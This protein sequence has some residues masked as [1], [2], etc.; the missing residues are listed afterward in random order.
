MLSIFAPSIV[1][2]FAQEWTFEVEITGRVYDKHM[3]SIGQIMLIDI[4]D[5]CSAILLFGLVKPRER[6]F[7]SLLRGG[8]DRKRTLAA[9]LIHL[10][11]FEAYLCRADRLITSSS[12]H[13]LQRVDQPLFVVASTA[14]VV[15]GVGS[16]SEFT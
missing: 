1:S 7:Y 14:A 9:I 3:I 2:T 15:A 5:F 8:G 12:T 6:Q 10:S 11:S 4:N 16:D 13:N